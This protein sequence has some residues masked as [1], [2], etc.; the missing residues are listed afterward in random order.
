MTLNTP[1]A[2]MSRNNKLIPGI[3]DPSSVHEISNP[4]YQHVAPNDKLRSQHS[5]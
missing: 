4:G 1:R 5:G 2:M 3:T